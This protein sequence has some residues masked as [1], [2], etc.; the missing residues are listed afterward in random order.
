MMTDWGCEGGLG[1]GG[2]KVNQVSVG[3]N[4]VAQPIMAGSLLGPVLS[5]DIPAC[6]GSFIVITDC[7]IQPGLTLLNEIINNSLDR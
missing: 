3:I 1:A 5:N 7:L 2:G 6:N 4:K